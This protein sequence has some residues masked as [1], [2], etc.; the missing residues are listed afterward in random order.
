MKKSISNLMIVIGGFFI[1]LGCSNNNETNTEKMAV[2][3]DKTSDFEQKRFERRAYESAIWG[4]PLVA[5]NEMIEGA[6]K[7]GQKLNQVAYFSQPPNWKF[8]QPTPNNSTLYLQLI[9]DVKDSPV[10]VEIPAENDQFSVFGTLLDVWQ[11]PIVDVGGDGDDKGKG[12]KYFLYNVN[13]QDILVPNGYYP[14]PMETYRGYGTIRVIIPNNNP[15]TLSAAVDYIKAGAHQYNYKSDERLPHLDIYDKEYGSVYPFDSSF[16]DKLQKVVNYEEVRPEDKYPMGMLSSIGIEKGGNFS[17]SQ[18]Q[19]KKLDEI[20]KTV[21]LEFQDHVLNMT[22]RRWPGNTYWTLPVAPSMMETKMTYENE[23]KI[24]IDDKAFTFYMYISPPVALGKATAYLKLTHDK[25]GNV[26]DGKKNYRLTVPANVPVEQFWSVLVYDLSTCSYIRNSNRIGVASTEAP[27]LNE[28]GTCDI[29]FGP[30]ELNNG[31]NY[32]PTGGVDH[33]LLL[34]RFYGP[35]EA[36]NNDSW[37][38]ND[39]VEI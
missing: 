31:I 14:V 11:R 16:Y 22:P 37:K 20:M 6:I 17:P 8:Q 28:D 30:E 25:N 35:T 39:I 5:G 9:Y 1:L 27:Q 10:I 15:E 32:L 12:G 29:Y 2:Q 3:Q 7:A 33:F 24:F 36:Y 26:L 21:H 4:Q 34:F 13:D 18:E 19:R 23:N 38:L